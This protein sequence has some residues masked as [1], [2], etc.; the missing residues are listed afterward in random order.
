M[1]LSPGLGG[2]CQVELGIA[3]LGGQ[4]VVLVS[5][6]RL[7]GFGIDQE[8]LEGG[9]PDVSCG[10]VHAAWGSWEGKKHLDEGLAGVSLE[11]QSAKSLD[12]VDQ[13]L[14]RHRHGF[15]WKFGQDF[16]DDAPSLSQRDCGEGFTKIEKGQ[17]VQ[18][19][20]RLFVWVD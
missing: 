20:L 10:S 1:E 9:S 15:G 16:V 2:I 17:M 7:E 19:R 6:S 14:I 3:E 4:T 12:K 11:L 18:T 13:L 8:V 5:Q